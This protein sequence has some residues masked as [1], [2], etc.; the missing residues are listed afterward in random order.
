ME[1][2]YDGMHACKDII[3][4]LPL[5]SSFIVANN[6]ITPIIIQLNI[7]N[8]YDTNTIGTTMR[9]QRVM[10]YERQYNMYILSYFTAS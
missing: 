3:R 2:L 5:N 6:T 9:Q 4:P 7:S 8:Q 1:S 10:K